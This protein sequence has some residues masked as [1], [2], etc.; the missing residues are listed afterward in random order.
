MKETVGHLKG[1]LE[2]RKSL[3]LPLAINLADFTPYFFAGR[4]REDF[5]IKD[6]AALGE[7]Q[8]MLISEKAKDTGSIIPLYSEINFIKDYFADPLQKSMPCA[9]SQERI[10]IDP[11]GTVFGGC[12]SMDSLGNVKEKPLGDIVRSQEYRRAH[13][14]MFFK[15]CPGCSCGFSANLRSFLP[16]V[17]QEIVYRTFP[18][19]RKSIS[20]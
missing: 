18:S 10:C 16:Y 17:A 11:E 8:K 3:G 7:V 4:K 20:K 9:V 6:R 2:L 1:V 12:W 15:M 14:K 19:S 5:W 13:K